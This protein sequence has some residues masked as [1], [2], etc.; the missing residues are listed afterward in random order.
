[1]GITVPAHLYTTPSVAAGTKKPT[2][3]SVAIMVRASIRMKRGADEWTKSRKVHERLL[4]GLES[5]RRKSRKTAGEA[6][7]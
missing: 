4:G 2:L 3:K 1:M 6:R 7:N 5:M